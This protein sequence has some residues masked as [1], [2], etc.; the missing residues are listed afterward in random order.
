MNQQESKALWQTILGVF[1][2]FAANA[3]IVALIFALLSAFGGT[4]SF[5][6]PVAAAFGLTQFIYVIPR[7]IYLYR[8][9]RWPRFKGVLIGAAI[10][11]FL[12]GGCWLL[13]YRM[14]SNT[15]Y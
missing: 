3:S 15:H 5:L 10:A 9:K 11:A 13:V 14:L 4:V 1:E 7:G 8:K 6:F 2:V 12:N